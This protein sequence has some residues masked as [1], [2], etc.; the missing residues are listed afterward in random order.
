MDIAATPARNTFL[1][2]TGFLLDM[3]DSQ[4]I[5]APEGRARSHP[6]EAEIV[7][8]LLVSGQLRLPQRRGILHVLKQISL[9]RDLANPAEGEGEDDPRNG[10]SIIH[11]DEQA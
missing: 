9:H 4:G 2:D 8:A 1:L 10:A 7:P 11:V 6:G 3:D 5:F